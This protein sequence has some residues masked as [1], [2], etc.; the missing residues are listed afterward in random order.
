MGAYDRDFHAW[1]KEQGE[2][3]RSRSADAID[4]DNVAEEIESLGRQER[5]ELYSHFVVLPTPLLKRRFPPERRS[6]SWRTSVVNQRLDIARQLKLSPSLKAV[7]EEEFG[8]A[9]PRARSDAEQQT[10]LPERTFPPAPPFTLAEALDPDWWPEVD[11]GEPI[12]VAP[13]R[14]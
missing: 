4:W 12:D 1:A 9:Y 3:I 10:R 6:R 13:P 2:L 7:L 5:G 14:P 11:G 8:D